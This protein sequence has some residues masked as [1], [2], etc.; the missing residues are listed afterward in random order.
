MA[1]PGAG[2]AGV[3]P[4]SKL[5]WQWDNK[6]HIMRLSLPLGKGLEERTKE[7]EVEELI[8]ESA[9]AAAKPASRHAGEAPDIGFIAEYLSRRPF[10]SLSFLLEDLERRI[11]VAALTQTKG[12]QRAAATRLGLKYTTLSEKVKRH[13][14]EIERQVRLL[15]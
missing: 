14:I 13:G 4:V 8:R 15:T 5:R 2:P 6:S 1:D 7:G 9:P 12:N 11:I 10:G 3:S